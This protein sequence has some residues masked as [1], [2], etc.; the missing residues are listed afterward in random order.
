MTWRVTAPL[1]AMNDGPA[2]IGSTTHFTAVIGAGTNI[3]TTWDFGDGATGT[4]LTPIHTYALPGTYRA[5]VTVQ[6]AVSVAS[7]QTVVIVGRSCL[8]AVYARGAEQLHRA[9]P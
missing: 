9:V 7:A 4:G 2:P 8:Q 5:T 1:L 6:N 3:S